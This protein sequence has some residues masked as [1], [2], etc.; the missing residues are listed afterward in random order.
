MKVFTLIIFGIAVIRTMTPFLKDETYN[1]L[2]ELIARFL[3]MV[4]TILAY[5]WLLQQFV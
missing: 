1:L 5:I 3:L 2:S 4:S